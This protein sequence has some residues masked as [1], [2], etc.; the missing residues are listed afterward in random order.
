[1]FVGKYTDQNDNWKGTLPD[2]VVE[3]YATVLPKIQVRQI[4]QNP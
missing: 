4:Q 2:F 1:M 3:I